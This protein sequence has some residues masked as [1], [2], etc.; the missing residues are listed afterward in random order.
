MHG[1][2]A[3]G[4]LKVFCPVASVSGESLLVLLGEGILN[5]VSSGIENI[6]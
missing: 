3:Y 6:G 1:S 2:Y 5:F 4:L